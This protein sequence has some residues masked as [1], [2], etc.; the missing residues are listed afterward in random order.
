MNQFASLFVPF[1]IGEL[2]IKNRFVMCAM[3]GVRLYNMNG[4][5]VDA[6]CEFYTRRA[7]GGVGLIMTRALVVLPVGQ[8]QKL[9][10]HPDIFEPLR[11]M[12]DGV[13]RYD[14]KIFLQL[15]G[16]AGRTVHKT[17][18]QLQ[19]LGI[20]K[21]EAFFAPSD[22]I[23]NVWY[24]E[25]KHRGLTVEEIHEYVNA[26][27][28]MAKIAKDIGFD[29]VEIHA[30]HEGYL[31]DQFTISCTNGR[32]DEYGGS[33]ENRFR[34]V[35]EIIKEI[36]RCCGNAFPVSVRYSITSKMKAFNEGALPEES[37]FEFGRNLEEGIKGSQL[38][39]LAGADMLDCDNGSYDAW[40]W[41][42]PPVYMPNCCNAYE[43]SIL[44]QYVK[45][46]IVC[47]G[48]MDLP[49]NA[50]EA[51]QTGQFDAVGVARALLVDP[52]YVEKIKREEISS[53]K[54]CIGCHNGCLARVACGK[55]LSCALNPTVLREKEFE[56]F[57]PKKKKPVA[58]IG[59]GIAGIETALLLNKYG[60]KVK[61]YE[62]KERIGGN[63]RLAA[64]FSFKER[65]KLLLK[66]YE[67]Q[68]IKQKIDICFNFWVNQESISKIKEE[69]IVVAPG[70]NP[71]PLIFGKQYKETIRVEDYLENHNIIKHNVLIVG[72]GLTAIEAA[73]EME[74]EG[75]HV[76][77]VENRDEILDNAQL[78]DA[79]RMY[80]QQ[81]I[82]A[83]SIKIHTSSKIIALLT[84][85]IEIEK[86]GNFQISIPFEN[87]TVVEATGYNPD[88]CTIETLKKHGKKVF[89]IGDANKVGNVY[90]AVN[91]AYKVL[92][93]LCK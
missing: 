65:D 63:F 59:G 16:G 8:K 47:A 91:D 86:N 58:I 77:I 72:G 93:M 4:A 75:R 2:E 68:L 81:L 26:F 74:H 53:I 92:E 18:E 85:K 39:E 48:K 12:T 70:A 84:D 9:Y 66:W 37:Y 78:C 25:I 46:P 42:H 51:V 1:K 10:E 13:H 69:I 11:K 55:D 30:I 17:V 87:Y 62:K 43:S 15:S 23:P 14:A 38:M 89:V 57:V 6:A 24:P 61:V 50:L 44:K 88:F 79:N 33:I 54:P 71:K 27:G 29:G 32:T 7:R 3:G 5:P 64:K 76:I 56:A 40:Y 83:S 45:I 80:L 31:L 20:K 34:M 52:D 21:E 82:K 22:G 36:K 60:F 41:A 67:D 35:C 28:R 90:M 73:I 49:N 19:A